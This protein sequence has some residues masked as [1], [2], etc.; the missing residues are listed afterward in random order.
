MTE[1]LNKNFDEIFAEAELSDHLA[2]LAAQ[3]VNNPEE[4]VKNIVPTGDWLL[5]LADKATE[6]EVKLETFLQIEKSGMDAAI[7][8]ENVVSFRVV[9]RKINGADHY[10]RNLGGDD[11]GGRAA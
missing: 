11:D 1:L 4:C 9:D 2:T 10:T 6:A 3:M 7:S 5:Y 8:L